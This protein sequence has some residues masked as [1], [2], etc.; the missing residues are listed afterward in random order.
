MRKSFSGI[1]LIIFICC[2]ACGLTAC[3]DDSEKTPDGGQTQTTSVTLDMPADFNQKEFV[4]YW[5]NVENAVGYEILADG[6][7]FTSET[8]SIDFFY[9]LDKVKTY[10]VYVRAVGDSETTEDSDYAETS[11]TLTP[12][13]NLRY[14]LSKDGNGYVVSRGTANLKGRIYI[15][16]TYN[17]LPVVKVADNAFNAAAVGK[18]PDFDTGEY[19][20]MITTAVR[21]PK[22]LKEIG[23]SAFTLCGAIDEVFIPYGVEKIDKAAFNYCVSLQ[24]AVLPDNITTL[25]DSTFARCYSLTDVNVP[26]SIKELP[27]SCFSGCAFTSFIVP[28]NI[29]TLGDSLFYDCHELSQVV[30]PD[31]I[32]EIP[33]C[34][35]FGCSALTSFEIPQQITNI[36]VSAFSASGLQQIV[37]SDTL[38]RIGNEAFAFSSLDQVTFHDNAD[39][40]E[41]YGSAFYGTPW[42]NSHPDGFITV[43]DILLSYK[44]ALPENGIISDEDIPQGVKYVAGSLVVNRNLTSKVDRIVARHKEITY[45]YK[46]VN[47]ALKSIFFRDGLAFLGGNI[48]YDNTEVRLPSDLK[49][50]PD[51]FWQRQATVKLQK[52]IVVLPSEVEWVG[53][54]WYRTDQ[55]FL[56]PASVT[57]YD[58]ESTVYYLGTEDQWDKVG[59]D[60]GNLKSVYFYSQTEPEKNDDG[61]AYV[62]KFW[63]YDISGEPVVWSIL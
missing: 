45:S 36:G 19:C 48:V 37:I 28:D 25:G 54:A 38:K 41:L 7:S 5:D 24:S 60:A 44:G 57:Y 16:D 51:Y 62:G 43:G 53:Y 8:N 29:T 4:L 46:L 50:I 6:Y 15:P 9:L 52:T 14:T 31:G 27:E 56:V 18:K 21:L 55:I 12:T 11:F 47:T 20:N 2:L 58:V 23:E 35:F 33:D 32:T 13:A 30:I 26:K 34:C 42:Y 1:I 39:F 40:V 63:H 17:Y 59:G 22:K 3:S 10:D 49:T 61:S